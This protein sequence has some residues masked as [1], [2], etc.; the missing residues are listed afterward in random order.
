[1]GSTPGVTC[2]LN[3]MRT[4]QYVQDSLNVL[5]WEPLQSVSQVYERM[6]MVRLP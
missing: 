5:N 1:V 2:V 4:V 6:N 3:G